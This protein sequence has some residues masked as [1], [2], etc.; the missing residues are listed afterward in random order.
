MSDREW[1]VGATC[2]FEENFSEPQL[3]R[4]RD[5]SDDRSQLPSDPEPGD[6]S[7]VITLRKFMVYTGRRWLVVA[8]EGAIGDEM[9][10]YFQTPEEPLPPEPEDPNVVVDTEQLNRARAALEEVPE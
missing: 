10:R 1:A 8:E 5:D 3:G 7:F 6:A 4:F 9:N 2:A